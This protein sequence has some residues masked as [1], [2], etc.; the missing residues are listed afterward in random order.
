[1]SEP[2]GRY[3]Y[4]VNMTNLFSRELFMYS[5]G[6]IKFKKPVSLKK[7][8]Y[9]TAFLIIWAIPMI[10]TF[11]IILNPLFVALVVVPP[12]VLGHFA[13]KP[14]WGGRG[15]IDF[16]KTTATF[17]TEPKGWTDLKANNNLDKEVLHVESEIWISRRREL[18][19]LADI[20]EEKVRLAEVTTL[21]KD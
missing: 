6:D 12:F 11:G 21:V 14:V 16:L 15:L 9:T 13:S 1:M 7:V 19:L 18:Q 20:R 3:L 2:E 8:G 5:L 4:V 10:L 17:V